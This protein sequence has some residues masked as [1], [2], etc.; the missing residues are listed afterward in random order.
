MTAAAIV[1]PLT[2][3]ALMYPPERECWFCHDDI[4]ASGHGGLLAGVTA[5]AAA[6]PLEET[7]RIDVAL[8]V[9]AENWGQL[10]IALGE[11]RIDKFELA[12]LVEDYNAAHAAAPIAE[13]LVFGRAERPAPHRRRRRLA[14]AGQQ[15]G[16]RPVT[17]AHRWMLPAPSPGQP[18][19]VEAVRKGIRP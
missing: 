8:A 19:S 18:A 12:G 13:A 16:R 2:G 3:V 5:A 11:A 4:T 14:A 10:A 7:D 1:P 15:G 9:C 6:L 17:C